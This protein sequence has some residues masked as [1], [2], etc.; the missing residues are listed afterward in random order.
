[1][2][3][4]NLEEGDRMLFKYDNEIILDG[5]IIER[6]DGYIKIRTADRDGE[7]KEIWYDNSTIEILKKL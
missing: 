3:V 6:I 2:N 1:M 4:G 5:Y 7:K